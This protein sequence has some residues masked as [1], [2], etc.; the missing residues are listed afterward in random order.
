MCNVKGGWIGDFN[1]S[2]IFTQSALKTSD[3]NAYLAS[4][5]YARSMLL[6]HFAYL[7][8]IPRFHIRHH[9]E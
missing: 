3:C 5:L 9:V 7:F 8:N 1:A 6:L 2:N 4:T